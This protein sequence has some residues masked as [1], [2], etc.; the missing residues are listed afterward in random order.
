VP[1]SL[2]RRGN[3]AEIAGLD[4]FVRIRAALS[5][6]LSMSRS[7]AAALAALGTLAIAAP[8]A[9]QNDPV[10]ASALFSE[11]R[12]LAV[13][14]R[15]E[16]ACP[17][18]EESQ[19]L[20]PGIGTQ[21]N[22]ADCWENVGRTASAWAQFL[23]VAAAAKVAGQR[24]RE[25]VARQRAAQLEP[26]LSR[27][28]VSV[29]VEHPGLAV[30][31]DGTALGRTA[32]SSAVPIDP[33]EHVIEARAPGRKTW[34]QSVVVEKQAADARVTV[35][36]LAPEPQAAAAPRRLESTQAP[37][38]DAPVPAGRTQRTLG[39]VVGGVGV[40]GLV[41]GS[42]FGLRARSKND[43]AKEICAGRPHACSEREQTEYAALVNDAKSAR[44]LAIVG[45][46]AG[47]AAV[48]AGIALVL[49]SPDS[50]ATKL[51]SARFVGV[52]PALGGASLTGTF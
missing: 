16:E 39:F 5:V 1:C 34:S 42:V 15:Y 27:L 52:A 9:A 37:E 46:A 12:K 29:R 21:F 36:E 23:D 8:A 10:A 32:W 24:D 17:K 51:E 20:D 44:T 40:A 25:R 31:K 13:Q 50:T 26:R 28:T 7:G 22:L 19:R 14:K 33:G 45:F 18:F 3:S 4:W 43:E 47:A 41:A 2:T 11:G 30:S 38:R 6:Q 35:P 48:G 49:W